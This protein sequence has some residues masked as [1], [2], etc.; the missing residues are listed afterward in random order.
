[1]TTM[2]ETPE[3]QRLI[4]QVETLALENKRLR[5]EKE[6]AAL[7]LNDF[8]QLLKEKMEKTQAERGRMEKKST[9]LMK[10]IAKLNCKIAKK[11]ALEVK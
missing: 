8:E 11:Q 9:R 5:E 3:V 1:M 6:F 10:K 7:K 2:L 4:T